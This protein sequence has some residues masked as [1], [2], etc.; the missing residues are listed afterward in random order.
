MNWNRGSLTGL[1][2]KE[3]QLFM[4]Y[5]GSC[6]QSGPRNFLAGSTEE[7]IIGN[8][9]QKAAEHSQRLNW[10]APQAGRSPMPPTRAKENAALSAAPEDRQ[11]MRAFLES[12]R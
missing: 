6:H 12:L 5:C 4:K 9:K 7:V 10:E 3:L 11:R 2:R 8:L 1:L